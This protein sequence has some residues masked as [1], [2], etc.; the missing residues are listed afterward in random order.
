MIAE[1]NVRGCWYSDVYLSGFRKMD[2]SNFI[3]V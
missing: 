2:L 3:L 1:K